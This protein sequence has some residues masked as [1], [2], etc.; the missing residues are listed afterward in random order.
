MANERTFLY[1]GDNGATFAQAP[2][3][4]AWRYGGAIHFQ[5]RF[6]L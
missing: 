3:D 5:R 4:K 1:S 6:L 2:A